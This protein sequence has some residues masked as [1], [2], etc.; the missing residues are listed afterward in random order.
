MLRF[1]FGCT[2]LKSTMEKHSV[3]VNVE[4][5]RQTLL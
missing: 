1:R 3:T 4:C 5:E 2:K